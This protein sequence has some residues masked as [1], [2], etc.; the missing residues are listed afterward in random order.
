MVKI[1]IGYFLE[2]IGQETFLT[3]LVR[4]VVHDMHVPEDCLKTIIKNAT[5]GRGG[6]MSELKRFLLD[7]QRNL[8]APLD[9]L[10]VAIDGNCKGY[11]ER[12]K[13]IDEKCG[14]YQGRIVCAIP[15]PHIQRWYLADIKS[16]SKSIGVKSIPKVPKYK[17][18]RG[19]YKQALREIFKKINVIPPLDGAEYGD[20]IATN[21][22]I[23]T[24]SQN[25]TSFKHFIEDL[26]QAI[27]LYI[28]GGKNE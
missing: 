22:D 9:I 20:V 3:A 6:V 17:C 2:D 28:Y 21:M 1:S 16:L 23:Y 5:G 25:D 4:R 11:T 26:R 19:R 18:E 12:K 10:I 7:V 14:N 8:D 24:A 27:S 13:E 15:N